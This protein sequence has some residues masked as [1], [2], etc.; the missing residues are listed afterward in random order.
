MSRLLLRSLAFYWRAHLGV[1]GGTPLASAVLTGALLVGDSVD[2][3]L[4]DFATMRLG[5]IHYAAEMRGQF[6]NDRLAARLSTDPNTAASA[7]LRLA[8]MAI[9]Q[10]QNSGEQKQVN[11]VQVLG[12]D[13]DFGKFAD[14]LTLELGEH[15][16]AINARLA[17]ELGVGPGD[18]I[19][20]RVSKPAPIARDAPLSQRDDD[21]FQRARCT[22]TRVL[23]DEELGRFSLSAS[24]I[25]PYNAFVRREWLQDFLELPERANM[26]LV[27]DGLTAPQLDS[28]LKAAWSPEDVGLSFQSHSSGVIQLQSDRIFFDPE[29]ARAALAIP[30]A[31]GTLAYLVN[32]LAH[33]GNLTPYSFVVAGPVPEVMADN[34]IIVNRWLADQLHVLPGD[35]IVM[36]FYR[37]TASNSFVEHTRPFTVYSIREMDGLVAE[38]ELMPN[39]P[40]LSDV[41]RC[42][43][44][45]IGMPMDEAMLND[46]ANEAYWDQYRQTPKAFVTLRAGQEMW[47]NRFGNVSSVRYPGAGLAAVRDAFIKEIDPARAGLQF[48]PVHDQAIDAVNQ[49]MD[50]GGLFLGL[51]F[52]LIVAALILAALLQVFGLQ[53]RAT[54]MGILLAL[55][56]RHAQ[57][58]A[59]LIGENLATV[60]L[61]ALV[62]AALGLLYCR[63]LIAGL[64]RFWQGAVAGAAIRYHGSTRT[65]LL[66]ASITVVIAMLA[67]SFTIWRQSRYSARALLHTEFADDWSRP[68]RR[69]PHRMIAMLPWLGLTVSAAIVFYAVWAK[70]AEASLSFFAAGS[71][72]LISL[73]ALFRHSLRTRAAR[74]ESKRLSLRRLA[75]KNLARRPGRSLVVVGL[76]AC[77]CFLVFAVS[78][79]HEDFRGH[80]GNRASGTGGFAIFADATIPLLENPAEALEDPNVSGTVL[81]VHDGDDA[82]CL[83]LN[84]AQ[85]PRLL[86]V[87]VEDMASRNAFTEPSGDD[88]IWRLLQMDLDDG[89]IPALVGDA[90]TAMWTL[91]K[92]T[93]VDGGDTLVYRDE[94]GNDVNIRLVGA[95]PMRLSVFQG[96]ILI[97]DSAFTRLYPS[98]EGYRMFL[99]DAP[100]D[101]LGSLESRLRQKYERHGF[102]PVPA[103]ERL[104]EFYAVEST[105]LAMFLILGGL[106]L[107]VGSLGMGIV[108]L[109]NLFERRAEMAILRALGFNAQTLYRLLAIEYGTLLLA[110][111][112]LGAVAAAV[113]ILPALWTS[114]SHVDMALQLEMFVL[115]VAASGT[116][117][118][119]AI[120]SG[121]KKEDPA[122]LRNE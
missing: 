47:A 78:S 105:Y 113:A 68:D 49:S 5:N 57:V 17:A 37:L 7:V 30:G 29:S 93:G 33:D 65:L 120:R 3:S 60:L 112:G 87:N 14:G 67:L 32:S 22:V 102:D 111:L 71:L 108:V 101:A 92:K 110:G 81:K 43:D 59:L 18:E 114:Q 21:V 58:R 99:I 12:V 62:G 88:S 13:G 69:P 44:W 19:A 28:A 11:Q 41:E 118:A 73:L 27:G 76:L 72:T 40:G 56:F 117:M 51:S 50:F 97:A 95:L 82:S 10:E 79:M 80:A 66:G 48:N 104:E 83:N 86:S 116:C 90:N 84:Y 36:A 8:G 6:F 64:A 121:I 109:R 91:K 61:G 77:G 98:E 23:S 100:L 26:L 25:P 2:Y 31:Q 63:L 15:E 119:L 4:R 107:A 106:G 42:A 89:A 74:D 96:S 9:A 75:L 34:E 70:S 55:G 38:K 39:F 94:F 52:F 53:Q 85:A 115:V 24:Q 1:G 16:T 35:Q 54:Q 103:V 122:A 46:K 45:E 20:L